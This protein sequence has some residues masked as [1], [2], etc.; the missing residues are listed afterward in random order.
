[1]HTI[2]TIA[3]AHLSTCRALG[4]PFTVLPN[5]TLNQKFNI[6][7]SEEP[8]LNEYPIVGYVGIGNK[9]V[10]YELTTSNYLL[11]KPIPHLPR[12]TSLY[13]FIPFVLREKSNDLSSIE[14][15]KY[16]LRVPITIGSTDYIAYYLKALSLNNIVPQIELRNVTNGNITTSIFEP[17]NSDLAPVHPDISNIDLNNPSG[18]YLVSTAKINLVLSREEIEN[19]M[20]ACDIIYGDPRYATINEIALCSGIDRTLQFTQLGVGI[21]YT[22]IVA[23]QV[24]AFIYQYHALDESS[25]EITIRFDIGSSEPLL[26]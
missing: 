3:A 19:I 12:H 16:R 23:A 4:R 22:D 24:N 17:D 6:H 20:E 2:R 14:K 26:T 9:G 18:D 10:D 25:N 15:G 21:N 13:N 11:T 8:R 5:S 1:M 7:S